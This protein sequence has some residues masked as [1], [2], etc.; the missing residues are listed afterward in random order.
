MRDTEGHQRGN[1]SFL[2]A[3]SADW[4]YLKRFRTQWIILCVKPNGPCLA[5]RSTR[6]TILETLQVARELYVKNNF[7]YVFFGDFNVIK[8]SDLDFFDF[9]MKNI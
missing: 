8:F 7:I 1:L 3:A 4:S 9:L 5:T 2:W 6:S